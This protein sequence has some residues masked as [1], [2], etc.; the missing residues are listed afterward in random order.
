M[1]KLI[2][3]VQSLGRAQTLL[4]VSALLAG[5]SLCMFDLR[6]SAHQAAALD[7]HR[8]D[9]VA[10][11]QARAANQ[12]NAAN[13]A[14]E[15]GRLVAT[16]EA[17]A[18]KVTPDELAAEMTAL[19]RQTGVHRLAI[20]SGLPGEFHS[21]SDCPVVLEFQGDLP[22]VLNFLRQAETGARPARIQ[23]VHLRATDASAEQFEVQASLDFYGAQVP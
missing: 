17:A 3:H 18:P 8:L 9:A 23:G 20:Q 5:A 12:V 7:A 10:A 13:G 16:I 6:P 19:A 15:A 14:E 2:R 22:A 4:G 21:L 1:G 11:L